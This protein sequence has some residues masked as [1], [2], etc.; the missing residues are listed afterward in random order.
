MGAGDDPA[1]AAVKWTTPTT[2][3]S[4][5]K[6]TMVAT[7]KLMLEVGVSADQH[8]VPYTRHQPIK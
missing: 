6:Y 4:Q 3:D 7:S 5:A 1:T 2:Y 8:R